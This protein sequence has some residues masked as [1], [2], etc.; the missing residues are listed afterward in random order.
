MDSMH[1]LLRRALLPVVCMVLVILTPAFRAAR[2]L[3]AELSDAEFWQL[4]TNASE[5]GGGFISENL[6][7][8]ELGYP[9]VMPSLIDRVPRGGVYL[10][11]GPEQ[12]FSY[13]AAI[14]PSIAFIVDIRRQNMIEHLLYKAVFELSANRQEFISRLFARKVAP[15]LAKNATPEQLFG[16]V[17]AAQDPELYR[18]TLA[19]VKN[20]LITAHGFTLSSEDE[21]TLE[22]VYEEFAR[23]GSETRYSVSSLAFANT[24]RFAIQEPTGEIRIFQGPVPPDNP[25]PTLVGFNLILSMQFPTY[26]EVMKAT[27]PNGKNWS[28]LATEESYQ[29]VRDLQ[30]RNLIV[31][32]VGDF[33]GPKAIRTIAKYL[34]EHEAAVSAFYVSNVEQ[35][36]TPVTKL[37][38]FYANVATLP[39]NASSTFIRSAQVTGIQP[40]L[41]QS[42]ISPI[43]PVMDAVLEGRAQNW[44]DILRMSNSK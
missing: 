24:G 29:A 36:L 12:N 26:A 8:N 3:P 42:S 35:Y 2:P 25:P 15:D 20:L 16:A 9:Y 40:G 17:A 22:H 33:A 39:L 34:R 31:P 43:Q 18:S 28:Y 5:E 11:V 13:M 32:V 4:A 19:A 23:L 7:S 14:H 10:G 27:D 37:Q 44:S 30:R 1:T 38:N 41:A 6:V 21:S